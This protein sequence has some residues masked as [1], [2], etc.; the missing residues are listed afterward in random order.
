MYQ[1]YPNPF[2]PS[3]TIRYVLPKT[4]DVKIEICG[5][6]SKRITTLFE[7]KQNPGTYSIDFEASELGSGIYFYKIQAGDFKHIQKMFL[8]IQGN[9]AAHL[10]FI[11]NHYSTNQKLSIVFSHIFPKLKF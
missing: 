11:N 9:S 4:S 7:G 10:F 5:I 3:T 1:N 2:N 6:N 8:I